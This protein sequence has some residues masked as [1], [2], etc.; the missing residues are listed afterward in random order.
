MKTIPSVPEV[1]ISAEDGLLKIVQQSPFG[2]A[3]GVVI[4][5]LLLDAFVEMARQEIKQDNVRVGYSLLK[6]EAI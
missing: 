5:S 6:K 3:N 4:P 2:Y 1:K